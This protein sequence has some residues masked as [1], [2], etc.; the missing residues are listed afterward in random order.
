VRLLLLNV[1]ITLS[2]VLAAALVTCRE[3]VADDAPAAMLTAPGIATVT[4]WVLATP[5]AILTL[6]SAI[7]L[8]SPMAQLVELPI[9]RADAPHVSVVIV[10]GGGTV[11]APPMPLTTAPSPPGVAAANSVIPTLTS[12][13]LD[14]DTVIAAFATSP[15]MS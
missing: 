4:G 10:A 14:G 15:S 2:A 3:N 11:I 7:A 6:P 1:A 9:V 5:N 13:E 8:L 12:A